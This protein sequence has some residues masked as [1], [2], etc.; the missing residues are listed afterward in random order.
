MPARPHLGVAE[1]ADLAVLDLAAQLLGHCLHAVANAQHRHAQ[2]EHR[3]RYARR[4][5]LK[6]RAWPTRQ[7]DAGRAVAAHKI[8]RHIIRKYFGKYTGVA[9]AARNQLGNLGTKIED[10]DFR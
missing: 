5:A 3:L 9:Y 1:F 6:N 10:E 2:L 7:D 8:V 4:V